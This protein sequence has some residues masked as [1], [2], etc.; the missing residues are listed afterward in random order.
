LPSA[1]NLEK[2]PRFVYTDLKEGISVKPTF[3][4]HA[5]YGVQE[6]RAGTNLQ[7]KSSEM[8]QSLLYKDQEQAKAILCCNY[9]FPYPSVGIGKP[10]STLV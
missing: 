10:D 6:R 1:L 5:K 9:D 8:S 2:H 7:R 4:S 3:H